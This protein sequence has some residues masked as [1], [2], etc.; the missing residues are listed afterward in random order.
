MKYL[1]MALPLVLIQIICIIINVLY[2]SEPI[3]MLPSLIIWMIFG[4]I[5][6]MSIQRFWIDD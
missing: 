5:V 4:C 1:Y 6:G 3:F 2:P